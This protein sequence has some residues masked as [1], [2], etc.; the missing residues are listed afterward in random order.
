MHLAN[1]FHEVVHTLI[2][3]GY[4]TFPPLLQPAGLL[5][6]YFQRNNQ[7]RRTGVPLFTFSESRPTFC[8]VSSRPQTKEAAARTLII[9]GLL[10]DSRKSPLLSKKAMS[11]DGGIE[12]IGSLHTGHLWTRY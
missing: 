3:S 7:H 10:E 4:N 8:I 1:M 2:L 11:G 12:T 9:A 5:V 6:I